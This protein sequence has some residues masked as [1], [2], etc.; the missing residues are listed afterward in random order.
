[1][2]LNTVQVR[3]GE[4]KGYNKGQAEKWQ[5][6]VDPRGSQKGLGFRTRNQ[7]AEVDNKRPERQ[8]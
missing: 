4:R 6:Q 8:K 1:M 3:A 7:L 2:Q 5:I